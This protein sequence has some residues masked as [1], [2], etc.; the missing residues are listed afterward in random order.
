MMIY[1]IR[2]GRTD[3]N[4]ERKVMGR[5]PVPLNERGRE[6]VGAVAARLASE[7]ISA[8][9]S[10]T[11]ARVRETAD[12]LAAGWGAEVIDE[13]RLDESAYERWVGKKY[14]ELKGDRDF[15]L[16]VRRPTEA[17]FSAG[18][19]MRDIQ[20]RA[21]DVIERIAREKRGAK[22]ALVSHADVI[23]PVVTHYLGMDLDTMHRL[24]VAN[25]SVTLLDLAYPGEPRIRYLNLMPWKWS[26][27]L[28]DPPSPESLT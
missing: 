8:I 7:G 28:P 15:E 25:A 19:G 3:W 12:I 6:M 5:E 27:G 9:Y 17:D 13:P 1:M 22:T 11:L 14:S 24:A 16:Y 10:G 23:K 4:D 18:E 26:E 20:R 21:L 2:H